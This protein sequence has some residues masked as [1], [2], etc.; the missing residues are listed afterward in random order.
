MATD[1]RLPPAII[2]QSIVCNVIIIS[3]KYGVSLLT[4]CSIMGLE[5]YICTSLFASDPI[6]TDRVKMYIL[7]IRCRGLTVAEVSKLAYFED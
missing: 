5:L 1:K 4:V 7:E 2:G 6:N 3:L